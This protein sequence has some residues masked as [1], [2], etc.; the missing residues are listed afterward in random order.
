MP[1]RIVED[2][3]REDRILFEIVVDA[4]NET[5]RAMSWYYYLQEKLA[6]PFTGTCRALRPTSPLK[7]GMDLKVLSL[8]IEDDCMS[9]VL[10]TVK[11]G[12][13]KLAVPLDQIECMSEDQDT[14]QAVADWQYW[15][16]RGYEY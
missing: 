4:Y 10:V 6:F 14:R 13:S 1:R 5:E 11:A 2:E 12:N 15:R 9:E 8:A 3:I 7:I 16:A